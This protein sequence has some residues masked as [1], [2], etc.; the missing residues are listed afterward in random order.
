MISSQTQC[1]VEF[2]A[3][4]LHYFGHIL[5]GILWAAC[6]LV[7]WLQTPVLYQK[8]A[9]RNLSSCSS[10]AADVS[11]AFILFFCS[12]SFIFSSGCRVN[13]PRKI[14]TRTFPCDNR[15][16]YDFDNGNYC[17]VCRLGYFRKQPLWFFGNNL[18]ALFVFQLLR[19]VFPPQRGVFLR[20]IFL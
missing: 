15:E 5:Q 10:W 16:Q 20:W 2:S 7:V 19:H 14:L 13:W 11:N 1:P 8:H 6:L 3:N 4:F 18:P 9:S 12:L 17:I